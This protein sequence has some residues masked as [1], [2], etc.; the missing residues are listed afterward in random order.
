MLSRFM[1]RRE[2]FILAFLALSIALGSVA[3][4][5]KSAK[6]V[7]DTYP[8]QE[9]QEPRSSI[10]VAV[11]G[12]VNQPGVYDFSDGDRVEDAL[13]KGGGLLEDADVSSINRAARLMDSTTLTI[14][15]KGD[16]EINVLSI[17]L[18][19]YSTNAKTPNEFGAAGRININ[20]A[21]KEILKTLPGVGETYAAAIIG[22][23]SAHP[24][25]SIEELKKVQGFGSK[26]YE[27]LKDLITVQ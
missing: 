25:Q 22:Y 18:K 17:Y 21:S 4:I 26:R 5:F 8:I 10:V 24:F 13:L 14:P 27:V 15:K 9:R 2:Q 7:E 11:E 1:T 23:R 12:A 3:L 20:E 6:S 16:Q 19:D